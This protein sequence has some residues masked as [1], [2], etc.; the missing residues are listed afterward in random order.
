MTRLPHRFFTVAFL[1]GRQ[2][3]RTGREHHGQKSDRTTGTAHSPCCPS[4]RED[5]ADYQQDRRG[6][7]M[8]ARARRQQGQ[9]RT[10][11]R[12]GLD[13]VDGRRRV[14]NA[15]VQS[16]RGERVE[17]GWEGCVG[18]R[19]RNRNGFG[20]SLQ[21]ES[22]APVGLQKGAVIDLTTCCRPTTK[23]RSMST[24]AASC[25]GPRD[26]LGRRSFSFV[27]PPGT[28]K[29]HPSGCFLARL[30]TLFQA[31][32]D[33]QGIIKVRWRLQHVSSQPSRTK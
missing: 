26:E 17:A 13:G 19:R 27:E 29:I 33:D 14:G 2:Q 11:I 10:G 30:Q 18:A 22:Q 1:P 31:W 25:K 21:A 9:A 32:R 7:R 4:R 23:R 16:A 24:A 5:V 15:S 8:A 20:R 28:A 3:A 12:G 6:E